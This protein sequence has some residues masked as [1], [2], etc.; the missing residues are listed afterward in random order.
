MGEER[1]CY[2]RLIGRG[3]GDGVVIGKGTARVHRIQHLGEMNGEQGEGRQ[4]QREHRGK[5]GSRMQTNTIRPGGS[6][7][8]RRQTLTA[9]HV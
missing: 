2:R 8:D 3:E 6:R 5:G 7:W 1:L 9:A 4:G